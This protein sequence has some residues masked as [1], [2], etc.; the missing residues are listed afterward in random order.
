MT[1]KIYD[2]TDWKTQRSLKFYNGSAWSTAKQAWIFNGSSWAI[3]YPEFP[4]SS[5]NPSITVSSGTNGRIG[6]TYSTT[7]GSWNA[8]DAYAPTSYTYQWT[9]SGVDISGATASTYT[10]TASDADKIIGVKVKATN[11]RGETTTSATTGITMLPFVSSLSATNTTQPVSAPTVTFNVSNLTYSG[12]WTAVS[13]ATTYETTYGGTAGAPSVNI[14]ARTFSGSGTAG[15]AS[16]SVRAVNT[17]RIVSLSWTAA[18]GAVSY[19]I[20]ING[21]LHT[22]TG[23]T[24][25]SFTYNPPDDNSRTYTV[26]PRTSTTQGYGSNQPS[27]AAAATYSAYGTGSGTLVQPNATSPTSA[28]SSI[29]QTSFFVSWSGATNATKYRVYWVSQSNWTGD[30]TVSYDA[31]TTNTSVTFSSNFNPGTTY[32]AYISASGDNNVW[33]PYGAYKTSATVAYPAPGTPSPSTSSVTSTS[34]NI[35]WGATT[36]TDSYRVW[37][38]TSSGGNNIVNTSTTSTS[39]SVTGLSNSTT[40]YVTITGY[41]NNYGGYGSDGTTSATTLAQPGFISSAPIVD[42]ERTATVIKWGIDN[43]SSAYYGG[44]LNLIGVYWEVRTAP[45]GGTLINNGTKNFT[46][47]YNTATTVN[48]YYWHYLV[49]SSGTSPD[50]PYSANARYLRC[51]LYGTDSNTGAAV[52]GPYSSWL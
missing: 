16:F 11:Q 24:L 40:Y 50:I 25:T 49:R 52:N 30:P 17:N 39:Y 21:S 4:S 23:N 7:V 41:G 8:D 29:S 18:V 45:G 1:L 46:T 32:Y 15:S 38:G 43:P 2:G 33:T 51:Q 47:T 37:V 13:N 42:F 9:R 12:S 10:T 20:Y 5:A 36:Y 44:S 48:G 35:S 26:Y 27:V 28:S 34:F 3:T 14:A 19:D 31:E 6:C 22:N